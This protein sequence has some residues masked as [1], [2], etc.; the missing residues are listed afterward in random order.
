MMLE[1]VNRNAAPCFVASIENRLIGADDSLPLL[2]SF[3]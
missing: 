1:K 3:V 2:F